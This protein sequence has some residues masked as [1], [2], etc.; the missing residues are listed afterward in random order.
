MAFELHFE[1][2]RRSESGLLKRSSRKKE[3]ACRKGVGACAGNSVARG[4]SA[5]LVPAPF[6]ALTAKCHRLEGPSH[7]RWPPRKA[8]GKER[9]ER[10]RPRGKELSARAGGRE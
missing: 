3:P 9:E 6:P 10:V 7:C 5:Q 2:R 8:S 1:S 4:S